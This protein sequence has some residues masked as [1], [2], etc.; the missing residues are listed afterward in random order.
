MKRIGILCAGADSP[1]LNA[2]IRAIARKAFD[3]NMDVLGIRD[4]FSGLMQD[5]VIPMTKNNVSGI[6]PLG[7]SILGVSR[8]NPFEVEGAHIKIKDNIKKHQITALVVVGTLDALISTVKLSEEFKVPSI[9]IPASIDNDIKE[10]DFSIGFDSAISSIMHSLDTLHATAS[11]HHRVM[12]VEVMGFK[13]G[14]L[15]ALGGLVG[16][17]DFILINER[18]HTFDDLMKN[19]NKRY[20]EGKKFSIVVVSEH[21]KMNELDSINRDLKEKLGEDYKNF[22]F[23]IGHLLEY[24]ISERGYATRLTSL[25]YT[26]RGG[27]PT[28]FDRYLATKLGIKAIELIKE[29]K[30]NYMV[31]FKGGE[32]KCVEYSKDLYEPKYV[33]EDIQND[34]ELFF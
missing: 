28:A 27:N 12:V 11:A 18:P 33:S 25:G 20:E 19:I 1:G 32:I 8:L 13:T 29:G 34:I 23:S 5:E 15:A 21:Y 7:G 9:F 4:G 6:L 16:G 3:E 17:A 2:S 30:V 22:K 24:L 14:W 31:G 26:Q 10:T